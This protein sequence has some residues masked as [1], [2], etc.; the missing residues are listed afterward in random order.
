M[1]FEVQQMKYALCTLYNRVSNTFTDITMIDA[2]VK[3]L[4]T[5]DK[6]LLS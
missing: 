1:E 2:S 4:D 5:F 3:H 6:R